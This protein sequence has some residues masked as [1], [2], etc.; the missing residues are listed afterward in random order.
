MGRSGGGKGGSHTRSTIFAGLHYDTPPY[1]VAH[2][3]Q[4]SVHL[5]AH[6]RSI[7]Q[8]ERQLKHCFALPPRNC[9]NQR[10]YEGLPQYHLKRF[11]PAISGSFRPRLN[12]AVLRPGVI[13]PPQNR[14]K[15]NT[16]STVAWGPTASRGEP[17]TDSLSV[18]FQIFIHNLCPVCTVRYGQRERTS[19]I[20]TSALLLPLPSNL[21]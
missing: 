5:T 19:P 17:S 2:T 3:V 10:F 18:C 14:F 20:L 4:A 8:G 21:G 6:S 9:G 16:V 11:K 7:I 15:A 13:P 12:S 1:K